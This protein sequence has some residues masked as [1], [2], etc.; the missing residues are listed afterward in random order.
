MTG[1]TA[2]RKKYLERY[3]LV[4][5]EELLDRLQPYFDLIEAARY[6]VYSKFITSTD[7]SVSAL[8]EC[9]SSEALALGTVNDS[10]C[11]G[12][13]K[14]DVINSLKPMYKKFKRSVRKNNDRPPFFHVNA[15]RR[16][17]EMFI[18]SVSFTPP[19][20]KIDKDSN[21]CLCQDVIPLPGVRAFIRS[22]EKEENCKLSRMTFKEIGE[23]EMNGVEYDSLTY[24]LLRFDLENDK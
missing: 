10:V 8:K 1:E 20:L 19:I 4:N 12:V 5:S 7:M 3:F 14:N 6:A 9:I 16:D 15:L 21:L 24:V 17:E 2:A 11:I 13:G 23:A 22:I 18:R